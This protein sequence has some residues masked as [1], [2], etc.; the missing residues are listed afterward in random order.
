MGYG[1]AGSLLFLPPHV[2]RLTTPIEFRE[3]YRALAASTLMEHT[4]SKYRRVLCL[5]GHDGPSI[6]VLQQGGSAKQLKAIYTNHNLHCA[7]H[8][9]THTRTGRHARTHA[10]V[11]QAQ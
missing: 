1:F 9:H 6:L 10:Y 7:L 8:M 11:A 2:S 5:G 4:P 3:K